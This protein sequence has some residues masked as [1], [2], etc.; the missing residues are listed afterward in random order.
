MWEHMQSAEE[1]GKEVARVYLKS[2]QYLDKE[3]QGIFDRYKK[4]HGISE[5]EAVR[6]LNSMDDRT[7]YQEMLA[8]LKSSVSSDDKKELI[9][10]LEA[11]A[12]RSRINRLQT[13][14]SN[15]DL[16]MN[17][18]YK[19]EKKISTKGYT[20]IAN[21]A[22]YKSIFDV[23]KDTG[24]GFAF[25]QLDQK[26]IDKVLKSK[27]SGKN[28]STRIWNNTQELAKDVKEQLLLGMMTGKT[29]KEMSQ[30]LMK[31]YSVGAYEARRLIRTESCYIANEMEAQS[32][33]ECG[34]DKYIFC[35]TLD[36]KTSEKCREHDSKRYELKKRIVGEN[37]P[38]LHPF[39]RST[40]MM[41]IADEILGNLKR[42]ARD[43]ETNK[44]YVVPA[45][46]T[47]R[48][49]YNGLEEQ[50]DGMLKVGL[51]QQVNND[52]V[53][54]ESKLIF[55]ELIDFSDKVYLQELT[56]G[57]MKQ[58]S[59]KKVEFGMLLSPS[60]KA[61]IVKG[62]ESTNDFAMLPDDV[63]N[64]A[65]VIHNHP[66]HK[67]HY[68]FSSADIDF[69]LSNGIKESYAFDGT[70]EYVIKRGNKT[71]ITKL[72]SEEFKETWKSIL[73]DK[74]LNDVNFI[75]FSDEDEYHVVI[76][77]LAEKYHFEY[78]RKLRK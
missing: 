16:M 12:Y 5:L 65:I 45:N 55:E 15:V 2:F 70:Y 75:A 10:H 39:C 71:P 28:Y 73:N 43:P 31:K 60:G 49:W 27:W 53:H 26:Q 25:S 6:I 47:Y 9:K 66:N 58:Y 40:V 64:G 61:Y 1:T 67:T 68:S 29:E 78:E 19:Q 56:K 41:D 77:K 4:K 30:T 69:F 42:R 20:K 24:L 59:N 50:E 62:T 48:D 33:E 11:P 46:T 51:V 44:N 21:D 35:A 17:S 54:S 18:V 8:K 14:Q 23:Q 3:M 37:F 38:P 57:F 74:I 63:F 72:E 76:E 22:Y 34:A 36:L 32:F 52:I 13:L 7:S